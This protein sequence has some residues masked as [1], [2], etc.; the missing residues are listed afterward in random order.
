LLFFVNDTPSVWYVKL[1][2]Y[3]G[4]VIVV[5][6]LINTI[7]YYGWGTVLSEGFKIRMEYTV[8]AN[9]VMSG[10]ALEYSFWFGL[11]LVYA[12]AILNLAIIVDT[13]RV[14]W[15]A[16]LPFIS[17]ALF[18]LSTQG[19]GRTLDMI[20]FYGFAILLSRKLK[21]FPTSLNVRSVTRKR[22][23][24]LF[25][26]ICTI[27]AAFM[28]QIGY[29]RH[30]EWRK[31]SSVNAFDRYEV[32]TPLVHTVNYLLG[33]LATFNVVFNKSGY[34]ELWFGRNTFYVIERIFT[35]YLHLEIFDD[36]PIS[37]TQYPYGIYNGYA[38][39][40]NTY[41]YLR[42]VWDDWGY[43]GI[44]VFP[45]MFGF[46]STKAY[47]KLMR[48]FNCRRFIST[49]IFMNVVVLSPTILNFAN[50]TILWAIPLVW[51]S[52]YLP[53]GSK[54]MA[55]NRKASISVAGNARCTKQQ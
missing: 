30:P 42:H 9:L 10:R 44:L 33:P 47:S 39:T 21:R 27:G 23:L 18:D 45:I 40:Q 51:L 26:I 6:Y 12:A 48:G 7:Q 5:I 49:L 52:F 50:H 3:L 13:E 22:K 43:F 35:R 17:G 11:P 54:A 29:S 38:S 41:T 1:I 20:I 34:H 4:F 31:D 25:F 37:I 55:T 15:Y 14:R 36:L 19:R 53:Q 32:P 46:L 28:W 2:T 24:F 8:S 16:V